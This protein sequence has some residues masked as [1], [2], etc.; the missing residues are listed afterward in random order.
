MRDVVPGCVMDETWML[1]EKSSAVVV[2]AFMARYFRQTL[3]NKSVM[4]SNF[5]EKLHVGNIYCLGLWLFINDFLPQLFLRRLVLVFSKN[6]LSA[7]RFAGSCS[8]VV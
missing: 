1:C 5:H 8:L 3:E 7:M 6:G 4:C 2:A